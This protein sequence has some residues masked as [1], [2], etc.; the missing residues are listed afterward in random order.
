MNKT[1]SNKKGNW[2]VLAMM[3]LLVSG[4]GN[5]AQGAI[6][7]KADNSTDLNV[8]SSWV[9]PAVPGSADIAMWDSTFSAGNNSASLGDAMTWSGI[10]VTNNLNAAFTINAT[11]ANA[12]TIGAGGINMSAANQNFTINAPV[13]Q[14]GNET[15][16][17]NAGQTLTFN[18]SVSSGV[19]SG[20][21][22]F[23]LTT[24]GAG[25]INFNGNYSD[26][27]NASDQGQ[28]ITIN[29][30][31]ININPGA[32]GSFATYKKFVLG[33]IAGSTTTLNIQSGTNIFGQTNYFVMCDNATATAVMNITGGQT[34][35]AN[36]ASSFANALKGTGV[37][38]VASATVIFGPNTRV[39]IG[40]DE[41]N[42]FTGANGTLNI[43]NG[44][45]VIA[46][47]GSQYFSIGNGGPSSY[48]TGH[49]NLNSGG[50]LVCG[51]NIVKNQANASGFVAFDG[52]TLK[53]GLNSATFMQGL[54][55]ATV[56][57]NGAII[58]DGGF[59]VTI[60][61]PLL[62]DSTL[63]TDGGLTKQGVG[64]LTLSGANT[65]NGVT[66]VN[67]GTLA[68][69]PAAAGAPG[70]Y[71][72]TS[73]AT[74]KVRA[75]ATGD[76]M[77]INA[78]TLDAGSAL[79][80][81]ATNLSAPLITV[82][83]ALTTASPVTLNLTN[84]PITA[85]QYPLIRYGQLGGAGVGGFVLGS[86][87]SPPG[88][89]LSLVNNPANGSV[90][91]LAAPAAPILTWEGTVSGVWDIGG[92]ANW[93]NGAYYTETGGAGP[94]ATFDDTASGTTAITLNTTVSPTGVTVSNA[95]LTYSISGA[96][97]IAG[98]GGL[99]KEGSGTLTLA[100][101][102]TFTNQTLILGGTLQLG[103]GTANNGSV[104]GSIMDNAA[105]VVANPNSQ[106]MNNLIAGSG[107][108]TKSG[109]GT[110]T[111]TSSNTLGGIVN[112]SAG[113]LAL[114]QG[115][116]GGSVPVLGTVS[117]VNIAPGA[118]LA[119]AGANAL[120]LT[121]NPL[122]PPVTVAGGAA[123]N[124][125][126]VGSHAIGSLNLGDFSSGATMS[127]PGE[128][129][130]NGNFTNTSTSVVNLEGGL[131]WN[132]TNI[133]L[134]GGSL[135]TV[136]GKLNLISPNG[137]QYNTYI[138]GDPYSGPGTITTMGNVSITRAYLELE[139]MTW[140]FDLGT[141]SFYLNGKFTI[142]KIGGLPAYMKW[143]SGDG[144]ITVNNNYFTLADAPGSAQ[145]SQGE[146]DVSGGNL[147]IS[148]NAARCLIGNSGLGTIEVS[149]GV[150]S[151]VGNSPI[152]LGGDTS[153]AQN[154][155][156]GVITIRDDGSL[157]VGPQSGGLRLAANNNGTFTGITGTINLDGGTLTTYPG[158]VNASTGTGA[159]SCYSY[160]NFNG[161]ILKAG[162]NHPAFL[163]GLT[164]ATV[165]P[166]GAIIDDGGNNI[167][168]GQALADGGG[169]LTK[170]G[171]GT[172]V[173][174]N[175]STYSG[176]TTVSNGTLA[177]NGSI[178]GSGVKVVQGSLGGSGAINAPVT[179]G[180][181][182]ALVAG[183]NG[184]G[185][186]TINGNLELNGSLQF[187]VNKT[188]AP[189]SGMIVVN[190]T[191]TDS[192]TGVI[193]ITN[194]GGTLAAGDTFT[195]FNQPVPNA[196]TM[197]ITSDGGVVWTNMLAVNGTIQVLSVSPVINPLP[198]VVQYNVSG[199]VLQLSW[200][201]NRGWILQEQTNALSVG[202]GDNWVNVP[203]SESIT[204]INVNVNPANGAAFYR[205]VHP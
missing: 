79:V 202:L 193:T 166:G 180:S 201:T 168:I 11:G 120:G 141:N 31:T 8:P 203:G 51:R 38:N 128:I 107:S 15:W 30:N 6:L 189:S 70:N 34:T 175:D 23:N 154:G 86:A 182:G 149:G 144:L 57:T 133:F 41:R 59:A 10:I 110:L 184:L 105:L 35:F 32:S 186:L 67:A 126:D 83:N 129:V 94:I 72:V 195:V 143:I 139:Y 5:L 194:T 111:L 198:G 24:L 3:L 39:A 75:I 56:S 49:L 61:Q 167:T 205:L 62:H 113:T 93:E 114:N 181:A 163:Q 162:T 135:L 58:D 116:A 42:G 119:L 127:G 190:G 20:N 178:A 7:V 81:D 101:M 146:L 148:N 2:E 84:T 108:L 16:N 71:V 66:A 54:T 21:S 100:T 98:N 36:S 88:L 152:Q 204:N 69:T 37:V 157:L 172:L 145:Q 40:S 64:T 171:A 136:N 77:G 142:G 134:S 92:T 25:T 147:V 185:I 169:G 76:A 28:T 153:Y 27:L 68:I 165:L 173:L 160:I 200:P 191:I 9:N 22:Q 45:T 159:S 4:I 43:N 179:I 131:S 50:T 109:N 121:N 87:P 199:G 65:Y 47:S 90:D 140:N 183:T 14:G 112:V 177:V 73:G 29:S 138:S 48:G 106:T 188:N 96:G 158:I 151:F 125:T 104:G 89:V 91:L 26:T 60:T 117:G 12:L 46:T 156:S 52:G 63:T 18:G 118:T 80:L 103:D 130:V 176:E 53:A 97:Q 99:L 196:N 122:P 123:F 150:L 78:L 55:A 161:G 197:S 13:I 1:R 44:G 137:G 33:N 170:L 19:S 187:A 85:G 192:G 164:Q 95:N 132:S 155:A 17:V 124:T 82:A 115:G 174:T 74:L 102:N